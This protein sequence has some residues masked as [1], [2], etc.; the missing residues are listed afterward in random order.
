MIVDAESLTTSLPASAG[1]SR[2]RIEASNSVASCQFRVIRRRSSVISRECPSRRSGKARDLGA[3]SHEPCTSEKD[4][5]K[6]NAEP[7]TTVRRSELAGSG[8]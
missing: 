4:P 2:V 5:R 3:I 7:M 1:G 6:P 8:H